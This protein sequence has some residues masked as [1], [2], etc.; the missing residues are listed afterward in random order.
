MWFLFLMNGI[1][2]RLWSENEEHLYNFRF[3]LSILYV[4]ANIII[5]QVVSLKLS[6]QLVFLVSFHIFI[7]L[8]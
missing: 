6:T 7:Y 1:L 5:V 8:F 3:S 4:P 2:T